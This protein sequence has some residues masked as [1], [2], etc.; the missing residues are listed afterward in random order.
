[1]HPS[2]V[3]ELLGVSP[4]R[5]VVAGE[6]SPPNSLGRKRVGKINGWFLSSEGHVESKDVRRHLDWLLAKLQQNPEALRKLQ[7]APGVRM[8]VECVWWSR[9]GDGGPTLWPE[10]MQAL[11]AL[12]LECGFDFAYYG[13]EESDESDQSVLPPDSGPIMM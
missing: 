11:A 4:T 13:A 12:N 7:S 9:Y 10:Q 6:V 1:M 8:S 2:R 5:Q 3:T